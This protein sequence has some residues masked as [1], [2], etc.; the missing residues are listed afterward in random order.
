MKNLYKSWQWYF[1][2]FVLSF[3]ISSGITACATTGYKNVDTT[4]KA[5][6]VAN[7]ELRG[8]NLLLQD[9][10]RKDLISNSNA[11]KTLDDIRKAHGY[12]QAALYTITFNNDTVQ[13]NSRLQRANV[14]L[15]NITYLLAQFAEEP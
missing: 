4:R 12:L 2:L 8:A 10:I 9:L 5:I 3:F 7:A 11:Q 1:Q 15:S 13:A 14:Y 6:L